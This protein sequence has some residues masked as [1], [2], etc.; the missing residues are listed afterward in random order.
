MGGEGVDELSGIAV[1][2]RHVAIITDRSQERFLELVILHLFYCLKD[3]QNI[4]QLLRDI[5]PWSDQHFYKAY[6][7]EVQKYRAPDKNG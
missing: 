2:E 5:L 1:P 4:L 7:F 3:M 6:Y